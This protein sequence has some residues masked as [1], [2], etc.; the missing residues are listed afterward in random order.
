MK[1]V[2]IGLAGVIIGG[3]IGIMGQFA[4]LCFDIKK[5]KKG[6]KIKYLKAK[7]EELEKKYE[8]CMKKIYEGFEKDTYNSEMVFDFEIIFP[9]NVSNA[10]NNLMKDKDKSYEA[11]KRHS[12]SI[13]AE[14]KKS[15]SEIDQQIE[16]E[17][18]KIK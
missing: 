12:F 2:I 3:V 5:W 15:L 13:I 1:E 4:I 16:R 10:F 7:K 18:N 14:M 6:E 8:E 17:I 9:K 11:K